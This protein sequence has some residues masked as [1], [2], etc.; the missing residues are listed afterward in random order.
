M[1]TDY[2]ELLQRLNKKLAELNYSCDDQILIPNVQLIAYI[3]WN[4]I[5]KSKN[6][7]AFI[8]M[9][10]KI[11]DISTAKNF[12]KFVKESLLNQYGDALLWKELEMFFVVSCDTELYEVL[13][14]DEGKA[15]NQ[16]SF[17]L[18][19]L[20]GTCFIDKNTFDNFV[21]ST[22]GVYYSGNHFIAINNIV[23]QWCEERK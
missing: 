7:C 2:S 15:V 1:A 3:K 13:K 6:L 12:F 4:N 5:L 9:P 10:T 17:S 20:L 11:V 14:Q 19:S 21:V 22:W 16:A 8:D 23:D 18:N